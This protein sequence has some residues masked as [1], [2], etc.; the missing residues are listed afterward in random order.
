[1]PPKR[2]PEQKE[3][4]E[5]MLRI[6]RYNNVIA[7]NLQMRDIVGELYG[8][9]AN[10]LTNNERHVIPYPVEA[11]YVPVVPAAIEGAQCRWLLLP[12]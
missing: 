2:N 11:D 10:F 12:H 1:M 5:C 3:S 8:D 9:T 7:W 4:S 6:G